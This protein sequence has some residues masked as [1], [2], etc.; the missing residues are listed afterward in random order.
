[1]ANELPSLSVVRRCCTDRRCAS[2][3]TSDL[4]HDEIRDQG[5]R[6]VPEGRVPG[7]LSVFV[8]ENRICLV[9]LLDRPDVRQVLEGAFE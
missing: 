6:I 3:F 7:L 1:M 4:T 8:I 2:F 9:E 5:T